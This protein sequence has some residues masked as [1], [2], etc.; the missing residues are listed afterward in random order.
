MIKASARK[1]EFCCLLAVGTLTLCAALFWPLDAASGPEAHDQLTDAANFLRPTIAPGQT[2]SQVFSRAISLKAE[3]IDPLV[4]RVSGTATYRVTAVGDHEY[5]F[6]AKF[7][8]DG[9]PDATGA[10]Q[11]RKD[12]RESCWQAQC[13]NATDASGLLFNPLVWGTPP[14]TMA[15]GTKWHTQIAMPWELGPQGPEDITVINLDAATGTITLM[16]QGGGD[17]PFD[18]DKAKL[19]VTSKGT[20]YT[21]DVTPGHASWSGFTTIS[22][23]VVT[24]DELLVERSLTLWCKE[25]GTISASERQYILLNK[26]PFPSSWDPV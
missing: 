19:K 14:G 20:D 2:I 7:L 5:S 9:R 10:V 13:T 6:A 1:P 18:N 8:Y 26:M 12:G 4:R 15:V 3:G 22:K 21:L 11:I 24:N 25:L 16:R 23:G 17:G